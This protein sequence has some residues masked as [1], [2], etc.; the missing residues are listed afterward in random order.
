[1]QAI[2][3]LPEIGRPRIRIE[4]GGNFA[5]AG[6]RMHQHHIGL[7]PIHIFPRDRIGE[8]DHHR[9]RQTLSLNPSDIENIGILNDRVEIQILAIAAHQI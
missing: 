5:N 2:F 8:I 1:M 3:H 7:G 4:L 9:I 6:K